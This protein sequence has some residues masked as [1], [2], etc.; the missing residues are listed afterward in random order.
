MLRLKAVHA[1]FILVATY[2]LTGCG[3]DD[4]GAA[5]GGEEA[6]AVAA[7][8]IADPGTITGVINFEGTP[9]PP[10]PIDMSEEPVCAEKHAG[11]PTRAAA[12]V[13]D[14]KLKN[15]FV[16]VKEGLTQEFP[17]P[18][19]AQTLDQEGC[20]YE[21]HVLGLQT[22]QTLE[23]VNSDGI[24]H[25]INANPEQ[26]RG[27]NIS[28]PT[29]MTSTR[30]FSAPEIMIPVRC[31]VHGWMEAYLGVVEHPYYAV[32]GD[33]GSFRIENL[34]PGDYVLEAWHERYGTQTMN[35][36]VGPN[37][38]VETSATFTEAM[39]ANAVV[40]LGE[41]IDPHDHHGH[42]QPAVIR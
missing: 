22:G 14:G 7:V 30:D 4:D 41:P 24:L 27:F 10:E 29:T 9:P 37:A 36:S 1:T 19:E 35:V 16:Y 23:I 32:S 20:I 38:T 12:I 8:E 15:V 11:T 42:V 31:D 13:N 40:P 34:P 26:N 2:A 5:V 17:T 21:P 33:D 25:N 3:G 6:A 28:Q 39:A 18:A